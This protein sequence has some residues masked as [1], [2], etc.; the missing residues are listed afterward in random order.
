VHSS[1]KLTSQIITQS[2]KN[3]A[4]AAPTGI[5][6][7][8][9]I[10]KVSESLEKLEKFKLKKLHQDIFDTCSSLI[11]SMPRSTAWATRQLLYI[12]ALTLM[13]LLDRLKN[14]FTRMF[15]NQIAKL[16]SE[17]LDV[18]AVTDIHSSNL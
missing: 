1:A 5:A 18:C 3:M 7:S 14:F 13:F 2:L 15:C 8:N 11:S 9:V 16:A 17:G 12:W 10:V 4:S 6:L